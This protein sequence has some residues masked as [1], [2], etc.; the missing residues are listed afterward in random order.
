MEA[1]LADQ[2]R[3]LSQTMRRALDRAATIEIAQASSESAS[4]ESASTRKLVNVVIG[5]G[6]TAS[7]AAERSGDVSFQ[8]DPSTIPLQP[9]ADGSYLPIVL[10]HVVP[11][12]VALDVVGGSIALS[13]LEPRLQ[14]GRWFSVESTLQV[15][16]I[17]FSSGVV[18]STL[19][20]R[21]ELHLGPVGIASGPRWSLAWG[22]G[23]QFGVEFD[24]T[25]L[26]DRVG[27]SFGFRDLSGGKLEHSLRRADHRRP[28]RHAVLARPP[29]MAL[30]TVSLQPSPGAAGGEGVALLGDRRL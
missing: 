21:G 4:A 13:W 18:S 1:A 23:S 10:A 27:V 24:L 30:G 14:L 16:D 28:E 29:G 12:R 25:L 20:V 19:G 15:I 17:Q 11:Y 9:L 22:G 2:G 7:R 5:G 6:E 3:W 26:Q 8:L